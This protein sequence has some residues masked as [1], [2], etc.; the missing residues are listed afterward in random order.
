MKP[1]PGATTD[2]SLP[3][4]LWQIGPRV[5]STGHALKHPTCPPESVI[6]A[7]PPA[8]PGWALTT[9][10]GAPRAQHSPTRGMEHPPGPG[11]WH[12]PGGGVRRHL[13]CVGGP[14][15]GSLL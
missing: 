3:S 13:G 1:A 8:P 15:L 12:L 11:A 14:G 10:L 2:S 6:S 4:A 9:S 7:C 5:T